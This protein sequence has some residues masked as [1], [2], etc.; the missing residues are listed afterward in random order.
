MDVVFGTRGQADDALRRLATEEASRK[1]RR[2]GFHPKPRQ[3]EMYC[4]NPTG[5]AALPKKDDWEHDTSKSVW[6]KFFHNEEPA[7]SEE[8]DQFLE[9]SYRETQ[10]REEFHVPRRVFFYHLRLLHAS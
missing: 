2:G 10:F 1:V 3:G 4:R 9:H 5:F 8:D 7:D 6:N